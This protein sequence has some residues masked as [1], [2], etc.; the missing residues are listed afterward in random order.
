MENTSRMMY[1]LPRNVAS[2][3]PILVFKLSIRQRNNQV[4]KF[5]ATFRGPPRENMSKVRTVI[6]DFRSWDRQRPMCSLDYLNPICLY[7]TIRCS[8]TKNPSRIIL[9]H[10]WENIH[11]HKCQSCSDRVCHGR[12]CDLFRQDQ[13]FL[14]ISN[15]R[16]RELGYELEITPCCRTVCW[17]NCFD[18]EFCH[19]MLKVPFTCIEGYMSQGREKRV[20]KEE[21]IVVENLVPRS[22]MLVEGLMNDEDD[23]RD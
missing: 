16:R 19:K 21:D 9:A 5:G 20:R 23:F 3:F 4:E 2:N 13:S 10:M 18:A 11:K 12:R 14:E 15:L 22:V 8:N 1:N 6:G 17:L 7:I